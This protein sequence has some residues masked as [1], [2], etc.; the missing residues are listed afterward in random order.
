VSADRIATHEAGHAVAHVRLGLDHE[1]A[2]I[3]PNDADGTLG[4]AAGTGAGQVWQADEAGPVVLGYC[5]GY[6]ALVAAGCSKADALRGA[7]QDFAEAES[8]ISTWALPDG[9][10]GWKARA[11]EMMQRPENV[12]AVALVAQ[13]LTQRK[14]LSPDHVD[15]LVELSDGQITAD[16]FEQFLQLQGLA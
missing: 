5:A 14:S 2:N 12:E 4:G 3:M 7:D 16:E 10:E 13:H 15:A 6:A 1:G 8:V 9:L 11:V